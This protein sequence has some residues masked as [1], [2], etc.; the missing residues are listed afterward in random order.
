MVKALSLKQLKLSID[1]LPTHFHR[2]LVVHKKA[3]QLQFDFD[4]ILEDR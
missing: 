4:K 3:L 1:C 2:I